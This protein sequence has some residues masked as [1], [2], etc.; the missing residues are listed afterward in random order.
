MLTATQG[1]RA[2]VL[3]GCSLLRRICIAVIGGLCLVQ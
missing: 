1:R 2:V 3:L